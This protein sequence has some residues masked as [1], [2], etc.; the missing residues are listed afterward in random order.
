ML[1]GDRA[2]ERLSEDSAAGD[3]FLAETCAAWENA[4]AAAETAGIRVVLARIG[5]VLSVE[6]GAL[7][8]M[9][10]PFRFGVGGKVGV[11]VGYIVGVELGAA[12]GEGDGS[13]V[14]NRVGSNVTSP[15]GILQEH[16]QLT[17]S[18]NISSS[19][20]PASLQV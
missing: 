11:L 9:L 20:Y 5:I 6:G 10:T 12:D 8:K 13:I 18:S 15:H 14:G 19:L 7:K 2:D 3:G 4:A 17:M 1:Y 16:G